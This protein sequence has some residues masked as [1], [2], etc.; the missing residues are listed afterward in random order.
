MPALDHIFA[1]PAT[2][3]LRRQRTAA[4]HRVLDTITSTYTPL[5]YALAHHWLEGAEAA[6]RAAD[7]TLLAWYRRAPTRDTT[8]LQLEPDTPVVLK[9]GPDQLR[10]SAISAT[11]YYVISPETA[12][13]REPELDHVRSALAAA[14]AAGFGSLLSDHA[15]II[16]LLQRKALQETLLSWTITRLPGTVFTDYTD[17][18]LV[19]ARDL[20]HE[21]GHNWLN[22]AL[23]ACQITI[24]DGQRFYSPWRATAR[25]A[26]GFLHACWAFPLTV[27]YAD[28]VA[29]TASPAV[30][31]FFTDY[32]R[33]QTDQLTQARDSFQ[34]AIT[35]VEHD[36]LRRRMIDVF[37]AALE[38]TT[39]HRT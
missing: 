26:F 16:C 32:L 39:A 13:A 6:A 28:R 15:A 19:L 4:I 36:D 38:V 35:L 18:P 3:D 27:L 34:A 37:D 9:P 23:A 25:P 24:P 29:T 30:R 8:G 21:A 17:H 12:P 7:G 20:I 5:T 1:L 31:D 11:P 2:T 10:R 22:D 33:L 14:V